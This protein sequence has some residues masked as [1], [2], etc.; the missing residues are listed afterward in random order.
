ME[1]VKAWKW[2]GS[3]LIA[4]DDKLKR[5][6]PVNKGKCGEIKTSSW[7]DTEQKKTTIFWLFF[8]FFFALLLLNLFNPVTVTSVSLEQHDNW[9]SMH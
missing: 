4:D 5:G 8:F 6:Y 2:K 7:I 3:R 9:K 1:A